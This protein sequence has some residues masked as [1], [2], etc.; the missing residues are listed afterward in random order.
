MALRNQVEAE[1]LNGM[2]ASHLLKLDTTG[3]TPPE[4]AATIAKWM[5]EVR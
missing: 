2:G 5:H 1:S 3:L 4:A